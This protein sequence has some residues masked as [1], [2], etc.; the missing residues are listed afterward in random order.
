MILAQKH[1]NWSKFQLKLQ[2]KTKFSISSSFAIFDHINFLLGSNPNKFVK[3]AEK[4]IKTREHQSC[5]TVGRPTEFFF[6][7]T[8]FSPIK[9]NLEITKSIFYINFV[10]INKV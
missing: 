4:A 6:I 2:N 3:M 7:K 1:Q 5:L 9:K 10:Y 8:D